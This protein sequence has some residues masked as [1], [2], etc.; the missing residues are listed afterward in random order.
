MPPYQYSLD[1]NTF[2]ESPVFS[3]LP[4]G[5]YQVVIRDE[6]GCTNLTGSVIVFTVDTD[7]P[8]GDLKLQITPN[9]GDGNFWLTLENYPSDEINLS[10]W[11]VTGRNIRQMT[12]QTGGTGVSRH[13]IDLN[14]MS[15]GTYLIQV[16]TNNATQT[17]PVVL[18][19]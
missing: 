9:P 8:A 17:V 4:N 3:N 16:R 12:I 6:R 10:I 15:E 2:Q 14:N 19:R 7:N 5:A 18:I 11:D 13:P 1:G